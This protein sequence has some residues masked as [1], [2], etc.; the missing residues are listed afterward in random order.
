M[1][2]I[3]SL[4]CHSTCL[5]P[6]HLRKT[7]APCSSSMGL[8]CSFS[9][10]N[11]PCSRPWPSDQPSWAEKMKSCRRPYFPRGFQRE[12]R[13]E[14]PPPCTFKAAV[15]ALGSKACQKTPLFR[16]NFCGNFVHDAAGRVQRVRS[17]RQTPWSSPQGEKAPL[18]KTEHTTPVIHVVILDCFISFRQP[19]SPEASNERSP[20]NQ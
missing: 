5:L 12:S 11:T 7:T 15:T 19:A 9:G 18:A 10:C 4:S 8:S 1:T 20:G 17:C 16:Q 3:A 2:G 14:V 13:A 6:A